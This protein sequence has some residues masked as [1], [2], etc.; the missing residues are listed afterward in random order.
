MANP[1]RIALV[2]VRIFL[3]L[4]VAGILNTGIRELQPLFGKRW[5]VAG[6]L[7]YD[8]VT[9]PLGYMILGTLL[10]G[11]PPLPF[12]RWPERTASERDQ[13]VCR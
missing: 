6:L 11:W 1:R 12:R 2:V 3:A 8:L 9:I 5:G 10:F 7:S 13:S 4:I